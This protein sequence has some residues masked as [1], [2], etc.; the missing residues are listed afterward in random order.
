MQWSELVEQVTRF[1]VTPES[2]DRDVFLVEGLGLDSLAL[3]EL[4]LTLIDEHDLDALA[5]DLFQRSWERV[6]VGE[7]FERYCGGQ[8]VTP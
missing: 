5:E 4:L 6:S 8:L 2:I 7:L 3:T 1:G